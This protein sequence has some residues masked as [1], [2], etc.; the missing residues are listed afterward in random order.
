MSKDLLLA[1]LVDVKQQLILAPAG[2]CKTTS[3]QT[4]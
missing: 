2:G 1:L 3:S 4:N